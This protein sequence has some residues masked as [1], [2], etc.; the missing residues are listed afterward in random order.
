MTAVIYKPENIIHTSFNRRK[1]INKH[2]VASALDDNQKYMKNKTLDAAKQQ[3][4]DSTTI[5]T[6]LSDGAENCWN[7]SKTLQEHCKTFIGILDWFHISMKFQNIALPKV[8][9]AKLKKI[10]WCLWHGNIEKALE[11]LSSMIAKV[12]KSKRLTQLSK[13]KTYI[14]NNKGYLVNYQLRQKKNLVF[15]SHMAEATVENLINRRC[16][17]QQHMRWTRFG[18]HQLL[19]VRAYIASNEWVVNCIPKIMNAFAKQQIVTI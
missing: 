10:K 18:A 7:I 17:G 14:E 5:V 4:L 11:R 3:G 15:T 16:K 12:K 9:K 19:Q 6:A 13:L 2:C 1:I 8:Q